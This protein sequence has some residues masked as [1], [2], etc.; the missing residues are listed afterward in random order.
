MAQ[1]FQLEIKKLKDFGA[2]LFSSLFHPD[3]RDQFEKSLGMAYTQ[4]TCLR[5][6]LRIDA[7]DLACYPWEFMYDGDQ[8]NEFLALH[9]NISITRF[10]AIQNPVPTVS[11]S[12]PLKML[13]IISSPDHLEFPKLAVE[14]EKKLIKQALNQ[15]IKRDLIRIRFLKKATLAELE[16]ELKR[17][18]DIIHFIGHGGYCEPIGGGCLVF[19][20]E[21]GGHEL[22]NIDRLSLLLRD[23]PVRL[24][25]LNACQTAQVTASEISLSVAEGLVRIGIPAVIAMQFSIPDSSAIAFAKEFYTTLAETYQVD[26]AVAEARRK[27]FINLEGG[28]IDW[29][30]PVLFMRKDDGVIF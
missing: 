9:R 16:K 10:L 28:R 29:G 19:E 23:T 15:L 6:K 17:K 12:L 22:I 26:R 8:T 2:H 3:I 4:N 30:I 1:N 18:V 21:S 11:T 5:I 27:M 25:V 13:V 24:I 20:S 14:K 7:P